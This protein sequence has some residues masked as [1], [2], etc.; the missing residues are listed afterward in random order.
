MSFLF[1]PSPLEQNTGVIPERWGQDECEVVNFSQS[2]NSSETLL[3][4]TAGKVLYIKSIFITN[5]TS[6]A[7]GDWSLKDGGSSGDVRLK[8]QMNAVVGDSWNLNF[9]V[10]IKFETDV[11]FGVGSTVSITMSFTGWEEP[12]K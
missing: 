3:T 9:E 6:A 8:Q 7:A 1:Q 12:A 10:P 5:G 4:V 2:L 11:Y